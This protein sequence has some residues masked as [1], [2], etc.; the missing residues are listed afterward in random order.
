MQTLTCTIIQSVL[1]WKNKAANLQMFAEKIAAIQQ[2]T[3]VVILP[4]MFNTGFVMEPETL[5]ETEEGDSTEWMR[6]TS[7]KHNIIITGSLMIKANNNYYN[8]L[9]WMLP[10]GNCG[11]YDKRHLF[12]FCKRR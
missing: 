1:H 6:N 2:K 3:E 4:E 11:C 9:L 7:A 5:A 8:R 12:R 10:N